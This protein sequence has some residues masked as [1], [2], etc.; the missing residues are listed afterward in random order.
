MKL[1]D[2]YIEGFGKFSRQRFSFAGRR[3]SYCAANGWGKSTLAAFIRVMFYGFDGERRQDDLTNERRRY[4]PWQGGGYGGELSFQARGQS[5]R[6]SRSFG[7]NVGKDVFVL[8]DAVTNQISQDF[9]ERIGEELFQIDSRSFA[10]TLFIAQNDAK[11]MGTTPLIQAKIGRIAGNAVDLGGYDSAM[12]KLTKKIAELNGRSPA[13][14][15]PNLKNQITVLT[16]EVRRGALLEQKEAE[17]LQAQAERKKRRAQLA[18]AREAV[19][20]EKEKY[21]IWAAASKARQT[22]YELTAAEAERLVELGRRFAAG[23]LERAEIERALAAEREIAWLQ[24]EMVMRQMT[25]AEQARLL[26]Y[27]K[28][29]TKGWPSE[30]EL[31]Q[32]IENWQPKAAKEQKQLTY[33]LKREE[34]TQQIEG[35]RR[36][37]KKMDIGLLAAAAVFFLMV[38]LIFWLPGVGGIGAAAAAAGIVFGLY[39]KSRCSLPDKK[40]ELLLLERQSEQEN[41][42]IR[43]AEKAMA[44]FFAEYGMPYQA[45]K[46]PLLLY[47]WAQYRREYAALSAKKQAMETSAARMELSEKLKRQAEFLAAHNIRRTAEEAAEREETEVTGEVKER[48]SEEKAL[49]QLLAES[50]EY[51]R[52]LQKSELAAG[53]RV[54]QRD[55]FSGIAG[56]DLTAET[57]APETEALLSAALPQERITDLISGSEDTIRR[58]AAELESIDAA[59]AEAEWQ[60]LQLQRQREAALTA[61]SKLLAARADYEAGHKKYD[62]LQ[63]TKQFLEQARSLFTQKYSAP[64]QAAFGECYQRMTGQAADDFFLDADLH[65]TV[66]EVG[67]QRETAFFSSGRQDLIGFCMRLALVKVMYGQERPFLLLDDPFAD[68]DQESIA[69]G[70]RFLREISREYQILYFT[71]HPSRMLAA[72][73]EPVR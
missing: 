6:I 25:A 48:K 35:L 59:L 61:E 34:L 41:E 73:E 16:E 64:L 39:Q 42:E 22:V 9:S 28:I 3:Q 29:F 51:E 26:K 55:D 4:A 33:Q 53:Q 2:C 54:E 62:T 7:R 15:L 56:H 65:L 72:G 66:R 38:S 27:E 1:L 69:K 44:D 10:R 5:Y 50:E 49:L 12:E 20:S 30:Q 68:W 13:A 14:L 47:E 46:L 43:G 17:L 23:R 40:R 57:P 52:L 32:Q 8:R 60:I 63:K 19:R 31:A 71:C 67:L 37:K 70:L 45:D 21:L 58:Y 11:S 36:Q 18:Q 24:K